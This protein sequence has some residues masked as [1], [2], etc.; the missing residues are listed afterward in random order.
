VLRVFILD[1]YNVAQYS[2]YD[3]FNVAHTQERWWVVFDEEKINAC[4]V[5]P[6]AFYFFWFRD[7]LR[8]SCC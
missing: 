3:E 8:V 6:F 5:E 4:L 1:V 7:E 2:V